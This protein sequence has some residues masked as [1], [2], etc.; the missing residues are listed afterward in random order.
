MSELSKETIVLYKTKYGSAKRYAEWIAEETGGGLYESSEVSIDKLQDYKI[1]VH[2]GSL[3][4]VGILGFSLIKDNFEKLKDK[5]I[6]IVTVGATPARPEALEEVRNSNFTDEMKQRVHYF[7]V[8]GA[9]D[10]SRLNAVDKIMM[11]LLKLKIQS[12]RAEQ[13]DKDEIGMLASYKRPTDW[14]NRKSIQPI[15][16]C[17]ADRKS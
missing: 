11:F 4:A 5:K 3:Y 8:R 9:F 17:I 7:H 13:R 16:E 15:I 6:I 10:Y 1:I 2:V 14:T 12:K